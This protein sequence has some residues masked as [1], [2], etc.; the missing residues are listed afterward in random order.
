MGRGSEGKSRLI[1]NHVS[2]DHK[3]ISGE[4]KAAIAFI[5]VRI[6]EEGSAWSEEQA[7]EVRW[8]TYY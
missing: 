3:A 7:C 2:G 5:V 6:P 1:K 4:I 8:L